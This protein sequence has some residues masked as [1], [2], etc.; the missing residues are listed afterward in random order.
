MSLTAEDARRLQ[1]CLEGD[2]VAV[3]PTDTVY[4]LACNPQSERAVKRLY[5]LKGRPESKPSA[6]MFFALESALSA[7]PEL[8]PRTRAALGKLLPGPVTVLLPDP[9]GG[10]RG[11]RV[12]LFDGPLA[13]LA[14]VSRPALQSSANFSGGPD[15]RRLSDVPRS[16]LEGADIVLDGGELPGSASTVIDLTGYEQTGAWRIVR[17]GPLGN[18]DVERRLG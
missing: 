10:T 2:G 15:P 9:A 1:I 8:G 16:L 7:I 13:A 4:G 6:I 17:E 5:S 3:I 12:P 18:A 11:L 14:S